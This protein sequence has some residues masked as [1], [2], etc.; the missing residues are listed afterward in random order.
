MKRIVA[1]KTVVQTHRQCKY[2][3]DFRFLNCVRRRRTNT[4]VYSGVFPAGFM[5]SRGYR[6]RYHSISGSGMAGRVALISHDSFSRQATGIYFVPPCLPQSVL[7][8]PILLTVFAFHL[9]YKKSSILTIMRYFW[10]LC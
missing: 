10:L 4:T 3:S 9:F 8:L 6:S 5:M 2:R 7:C 1:P